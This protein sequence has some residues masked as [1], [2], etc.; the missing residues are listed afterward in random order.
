MFLESEDMRLS[1]RMGVWIPS[2][3]LDYL[4]DLLLLEHPL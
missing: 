2:L 1:D 4:S 3:A